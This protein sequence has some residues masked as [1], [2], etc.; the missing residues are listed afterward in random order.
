M[1]RLDLNDVT[2]GEFPT[3]PPA[4]KPPTVPRHGP[5]ETFLKG[6]IPWC[7]LATAASLP[8]RC[9]HVG[10]AIWHLHWLQRRPKIRLSNAILQELG[11]D[12]HAKGRALKRLEVAGLIAIERHAGSSPLILLLDPRA[13][14]RK[15]R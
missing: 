7:W 13:R 8:G 4:N 5:G 2:W 10:L 6:P 9:L 14:E 3:Q 1:N 12:K 15:S 11:V